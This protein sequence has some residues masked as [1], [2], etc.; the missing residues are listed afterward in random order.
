MSPLVECELVCVP[1]ESVP[2]IWDK[3]S[4]L[5]ESAMKR[6]RMGDFGILKENLFS[7]RALLW[8][9]SDVKGVAAAAVTELDIANGEKFCT[10]TACAGEE[11]P[12]W[13]NLLGRIEQFAK[14]EGCHSMRVNGRQGWLKVLPNYRIAAVVLEKELN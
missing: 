11:M 10:L 6:G 9:A 5:L 3:V 13:F 4:G 8:L 2:K 7:G 14:D 1:P 12:R